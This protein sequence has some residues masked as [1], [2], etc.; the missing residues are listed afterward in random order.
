M[1]Y[2]NYLGQPMPESASPTQN[3]Y[4]TSAGGETLTAPAGPS[5]V[6]SNGGTGDVLIGSNG[7]NIFYVK[8]PTDLV[9]VASGLT[10]VKTVV[11]YTNFALPDH[12]QNLTFSG[13]NV[14]G[15]GN[16]LDNLIIAGADPG[17]TLYGGGGNDVLVGGAGPD[18]F[19][20]K[21]GEGNDVV[22]NW[23]A[24]DQIQLIGTSFH[25]FADVQAAMTQVGPDV[26]L[27]LD[28]NETLT[29]RGVT[30]AAF[31]AQQML[32]PLDRSTLG[33]MTFDDEFNS[34]QKYDFSTNTGTWQT[35]FGYDPH[36]A[37][38]YSLLQN[39]EQQRY[40]D[41]NFQGT[42][43]HPLGI[44]PFSD[45]NGVLTI[46]ASQIPSDLQGYAYGGGYAS[47][48]IDTRGIFEQ[49]YGYFEVRM[50]IPT[51]AT[52]AWPAFWMT[53][54]PNPSGVEADITENTAAQ[55]PFDFVR[56]YGGAGNAAAFSNVLKTGDITGFHTY[57]MLWTPQTIT[58]YY[59]DQAVFSAPTPATWTNPMYLIANLAIGGFGGNPDPTKFPAQMQIDYIHAYALADGSSTVEHLTPL[60]PGGTLRVNGAAVAGQPALAVQT[61]ADDGTPVTSR[62]V[63]HLSTDPAHASQAEIDAAGTKAL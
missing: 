43:D 41:A 22:Y 17:E 53:P 59:D 26:V 32:L 19:M 45:S 14:Y 21:V 54:D 23:N 1:P 56:G 58:F 33:P 27:Q 7:D 35:N 36:N 6:D 13:A 57:G 62:H 48:M 52:G 5:S 30:P 2:D 44:N 12:V 42:A 50:A 20:V 63:V 46:T 60:A 31:T 51:A 24:G 11:A 15:A 18:T 39:G 10:G 61:F 16:S 38:N 34:F 28:P 4:G 29:F 49:K 40:I 9:Q 37:G 55:N 3:V 25:S 8:D 47:G